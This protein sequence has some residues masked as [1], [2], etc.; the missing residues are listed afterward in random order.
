MTRSIAAGSR[1]R[2]APF[3][4]SVA[5]PCAV[6]GVTL[7]DHL[8]EQSEKKGTE[9]SLRLSAYVSTVRTAP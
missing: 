1:V 6:S 7:S 4:V 9:V 5:T 2:V 3:G 8:G